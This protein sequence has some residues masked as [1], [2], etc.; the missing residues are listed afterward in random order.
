M[1]SGTLGVNLLRN[2]LERKGVTGAERTIRA[3]Q[4]Y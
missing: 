1:L 2:M 4:E 3:G